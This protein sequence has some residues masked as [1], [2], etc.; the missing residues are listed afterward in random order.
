MQVQVELR[1]ALKGHNNPIYSICAD[2]NDKKFYTAGNDKGIVEW[3]LNE[4]KF[5][6]IVCP[7]QHS[8]YALVTHPLKDIL[9]A[10]DS[11]G[12]LLQVDL[13]SGNIETFAFSQAPIFDLKINEKGE[14]WILHQ[15][16]FIVKFDTENSLK[17]AEKH[18]F[19]SKFRSFDLDIH[20][21]EI[22]TGDYEGN[23]YILDSQLELI[24][25]RK[26]AESSITSIKKD[27]QQLWIGNRDAEI[28]A[29]N[30][31]LDKEVSW[32]PHMF[33]IYDIKMHPTLPLMATSSR[34]KDVKIWSLD[35]YKLKRSISI[36]KE[37]PAHQLSVNKIVWMNED[38]L[39]SVGDDR[40]VLVWDVQV[41][42]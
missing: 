14:L 2:K 5:S 26:V 31:T 39:I 8:V 32:V 35:D 28:A 19:L 36:T 27:S 10:G 22:I 13:L 30:S 33:A 15:N 6:R 7:I 23:V 3:D 12:N 1:S 37:L 38:T 20:T 29:L 16:G 11:K 42:I 4:L 17:I 41:S 9:Y 40:M 18:V 24:S 21:S 25:Q 34:D